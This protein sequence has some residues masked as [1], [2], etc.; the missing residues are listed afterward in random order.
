MLFSTSGVFP[1]GV[2]PYGIYDAIPSFGWEWLRE[3]TDRFSVRASPGVSKEDIITAFREEVLQIPRQVWTGIPEE[4]HKWLTNNADRFRNANPVDVQS[5]E[6]MVHEAYQ[7]YLISKY[8]HLVP[9]YGQNWITQHAQTFERLGSSDEQIRRKFGEYMMSNH[10]EIAEQSFRR[11][12]L[13][14]ESVT[15]ARSI[16][17]LEHSKT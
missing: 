13:K 9:S 1:P 12:Q 5:F 2:F 3:N 16:A 17:G 15:Y 6:A 14:A 10:G 4:A 7:Q 11:Q 8:A